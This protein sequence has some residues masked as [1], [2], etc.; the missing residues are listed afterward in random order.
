MTT[1]KVGTDKSTFIPVPEV[2]L[3]YNN[4]PDEPVDEFDGLF[5]HEEGIILLTNKRTKEIYMARKSDPDD[6]F[7]HTFPGSENVIVVMD[8]WK[9]RKVSESR[10]QSAN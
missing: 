5:P 1:P 3:G 10:R 2:L 7:T 9:R 8:E 4:K 6:E